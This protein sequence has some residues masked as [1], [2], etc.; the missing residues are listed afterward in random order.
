MRRRILSLREKAAPDERKRWSLTAA[1]ML[2]GFKPLVNA[3][4]VMAF[5]SFRSEIDTV[6]VLADI[7]SRKQRLVLPLSLVATREMAIY[8]I[9]DPA[10]QLRRGYCGIPEPDPDLCS[11][12]P[13]AE[14]DLVLVPGS[15]F[16]LRGGRMGYGGGYYDRFLADKA[17]QALRVGLAFSLQLL[18]RIPQAPHDQRMDYVVT[19]KGVID[20]RAGM[21]R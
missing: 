8:K 20:C 14:V 7:L 12:V 6:P 10:A 19:E 9:K 4:T 16:D 3:R 13:A 18:E 17:P 2:A 1:A 15:V 5:A 11:E 21:V